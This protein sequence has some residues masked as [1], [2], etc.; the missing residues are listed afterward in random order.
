VT[1]QH[2]NVARQSFD[3]L[4]RGDGT[5]TTPAL[6]AT[7]TQLNVYP[8]PAVNSVRLRVNDLTAGAL[9][10]VYNGQGTSVLTQSLSNAEQMVD[11]STLPIGVYLLKVN[12]GT[13]R[14]VKN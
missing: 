13:Q 12:N 5:C 1:D 6:A 7:S 4:V 8:N 10:Q 2:G 11:L 3:I 9:V 14:V